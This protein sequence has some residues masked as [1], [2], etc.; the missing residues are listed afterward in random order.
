MNMGS[1]WVVNVNLVEVGKLRRRRSV[2]FAGGES[3][4]K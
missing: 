4:R 3:K 2:V 1:W